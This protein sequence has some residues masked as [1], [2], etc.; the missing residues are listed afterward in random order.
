[1]T[2]LPVAARNRAW[3]TTLFLLIATIG[4]VLF[5]YWDT[6]RAMVAIWAVFTIVLFVAEPLFLHRWFHA[7]ALRDPE[8]AFRL[9]LR[10]HRV[11][12]SLSLIAVAGAVL[13]AHGALP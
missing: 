7:R 12:L 9:V 2:A 5:W 4:W 1:M 8:E 10:L 6:A 11:L 3:P 13:G